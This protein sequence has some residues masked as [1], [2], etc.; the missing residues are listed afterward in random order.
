MEVWGEMNPTNNEK[1]G[2]CKLIISAFG[3]VAI[4]S[5]ELMVVASLVISVYQS[6]PVFILALCSVPL[7]ILF[8]LA[9]KSLDKRLADYQ[10]S[11]AEEL[12][13]AESLLG[14]IEPAENEHINA[15]LSW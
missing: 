1:S 9:V 8:C 2:L 15:A 13:R 4:L 5:V 14:L 6:G 3:V 12:P 7:I 11:F 10:D